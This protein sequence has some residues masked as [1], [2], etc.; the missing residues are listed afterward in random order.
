[1]AVVQNLYQVFKL[2]AS[3]L[4]KNDCKLTY[5]FSKAFKEGNIVSIGDNLVFQQLRYIHGDYRD[6]TELFD[7]VTT[8]RS[9][10]HRYKK[11]GLYREAR[12]LN[13]R[14]SKVLFVEDIVNVYIDGKKSDFHAFRTKGFD[15]NGTHY[16]YLCSG[17]GQIRRN[18]ATFI[19]EKYRDQ[20]VKTLNCG[21][22]EK[23]T[24]FVLAKYSAYFALAF[25]SILW[26]RTPRVCLIKDFY[27]TLKQEPVD[28]IYHD[29][30]DGGKAKIEERK[31][32]LELNC[33][34]GQ[35]LI[36]PEFAKLWSEDMKLKV[37]SQHLILKL[38]LMNMVLL[39]LE[40]VGEKS[41][42]LMI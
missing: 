29:E 41:I 17:S 3:M 2:P 40:I 6:H 42:T 27:N 25:S 20:V 10:M 15:L 19:N 11:A 32:D 5:K 28:F 37:I 24:D 22:D 16:V 38:M 39:Q 31:M 30:K 8:L 7:Y 9:S 18:T 26:V 14:I 21:L 36:D 13:Q 33:A 34:D 4:V 1:M 23:T 35:G 12:I